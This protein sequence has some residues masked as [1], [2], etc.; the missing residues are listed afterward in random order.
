MALGPARERSGPL[1]SG[2]L[3]AVSHLQ[4]LGGAQLR[5]GVRHWS[6]AGH[7]G[8]S[9]RS[10]KRQTSSCTSASC[11]RGAVVSIC[12][13]IKGGRNQYH[14]AK[15]R[16]VRLLMAPGQRNAQWD[17]K[18]RPYVAQKP[19]FSSMYFMTALSLRCTWMESLPC[20]E[21]KVIPPTLSALVWHRR[22]TEIRKW[23]FEKG[24]FVAASEWLGEKIYDVPLTRPDWQS[25]L[26]YL[27]A[28]PLNPG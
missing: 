15:G 8:S 16:T 23:T 25:K 6:P 13:Y 3:Q 20:H 21:G 4:S 19:S 24:T 22:C 7:G 28:G 9:C 27:K 17:V 12:A 26:R 11:K 18:G 10:P 1:S 2:R 14:W 5:Q